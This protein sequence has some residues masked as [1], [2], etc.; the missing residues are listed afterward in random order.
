MYRLGRHLSISSSTL[1]SYISRDSRDVSQRNWHTQTDVHDRSEVNDPEKSED[2]TFRWLDDDDNQSD[3]GLDDYHTAVAETARLDASLICRR[4]S[5]S[6]R[7]S[8]LGSIH[9]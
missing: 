7:E 3:M 5:S 8:Y 2:S 4:R 6:R 1:K 9:F